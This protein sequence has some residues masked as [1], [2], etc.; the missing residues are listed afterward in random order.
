MKSSKVL[1]I[2]GSLALLH[3]GGGVASKHNLNLCRKL[4]GK[5]NVDAIAFSYSTTLDLSKNDITILPGYKN[6]FSTFYNSIRLF[7]GGL[8]KKSQNNIC[9]IITNYDTYF[10]DSSLFGRICP[11][12]KSINPEAKIFTFFHNVEFDF[13][14]GMLKSRFFLYYSIFRSA[15]YNE[16]NAI[17]YSDYI[18]VFNKRDSVRLKELYG[19]GGDLI[20]PIT[21]PDTFDSSKIN[22][23]FSTEKKYLFVGSAFHANINGIIWFIKN[24]FPYI[25]GKLQIIG[26]GME[27]LQPVIKDHRIE[28]IGF[29]EDLSSYYYHADFI[30]MPIF[31][32]SGIKIKTA[33]ALMY[34]KTILG[35]QEAFEGYEIENYKIGERCDSATDFISTINKYISMKISTKFNKDSRELFKAKYDNSTLEEIIISI[36]KNISINPNN[37]ISI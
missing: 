16:R 8:S 23:E 28:V 29:V 3:T 11:V 32:G 30:V 4:F 26:K 33:E 14:K 5:N 7:S 20:V 27:E 15:S 13:M 17:K 34:G 2:S 37:K 1:F 12:I 18:L 19:R 6:K 36:K 31:E 10:L 24:V 9:Q 22:T 21:L 25:P 35:T